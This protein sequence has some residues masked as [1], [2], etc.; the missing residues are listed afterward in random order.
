MCRCCQFKAES[1]HLLFSFFLTFLLQLMKLYQMKPEEESMTSMVAALHTSLGRR[2]TDINKVLINLSTLTTYSRTLTSTARTGMPVTEDTLRNTPGPTRRPTTDTRDTFKE[3]S[4]QVSLM[5]CL[6]ILRGCLLS[7]D[8]QNRLKA[9]FT[10]H[11]NNTV[12]Q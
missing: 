11:Q 1:S 12:E 5:T 6:T 8:T 4:E 7:T 2:K 3:V 9:G 10:V